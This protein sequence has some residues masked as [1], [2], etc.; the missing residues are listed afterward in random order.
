MTELTPAR[1]RVAPSPTGDPHVGTAFMALFDKAWAAKTGGSFVLRIED[2][3]QNRLVE[4]SEEQIHDT[5]AWLGLS[6]DEGPLEGGDF[7][8]Y[9]QS[10]RPG[11]HRP[12][13][14]PLNADGHAHH[15]RRSSGR[16]AASVAAAK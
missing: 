15:C 10:E 5:L 14:E 3:D 12:F 6:P 7:G 16:P 1:T 8:P 2:T 11:T 13:V 4:G 9:R